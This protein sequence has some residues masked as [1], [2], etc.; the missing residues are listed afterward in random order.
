MKLIQ[1]F[2]LLPFV[3]TLS[4]WSASPVPYSGKID[5]RGVNYFGEAQFAFSLHDGNGTTHWENGNQPKE[6]I[7]VTIRNGRYSVLLGGQGMN[8]LAPQ[9]FLN[10]DKLYLKVEVDMGDG[11]GL[12][13][14]APDQLITATPR[15]LVA[16]WAKM[17]KL[18][19][20]VPA[21]SITRDMLSQQVLTQ[22]D[23]NGSS[24]TVGP[25]TRDMLPASVLN[26]LNKT[27]VITRD[28]LPQDVRDDLNQSIVI[29]RDMLPQDVRD[30]LNK[31]VM[32]TRS[33]LPADVLSDLNR[34]IS[35]SMLGSDLIADLN[36]TIGLSRLSSEVIAK[37]NQN[38]TVADGSVTASKIASK[39]I[40]KDQISDSI[41]KYLKPEITAQPQAS[42]IYAA[43]DGTVSFSAEGKYL[44]Y[45]WKKNSLDLTGE[46]NATLNITDAN[47]T[48]HGGNYSVVVSNDFGSVESGEVEMF[49]NNTGPINGLVGWWKFDETSGIV[50]YDSSGNGNDGNLT[51][52]PTWTTGKIGGA[53]SFD[54]FDDLVTMGNVTGGLLNFTLSTWVKTN[55]PRS[56][57][58]VWKNPAILGT[59]QLSGSGS[60][61][62]LLGL[63]GGRLIWFDEIQ[64]SM[65]FDTSQQ[66]ADNKWCFIVFTR[67]N[68][69]YKFFIGGVLK[70]E[71]VGTA[72]VLAERTIDVGC[73]LYSGVYHFNGLIDDVRIYD[74][75]LSVAEVQSLYNMG[76]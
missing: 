50:A 10:H 33:M 63:K 31:T 4:L 51:N 66:I 55:D 17:A 22:L 65:T 21:G 43:G 74:R 16:E 47:A 58:T 46:T 67:S 73:S 27:I 53:L 18:A 13:H 9:L 5:I 2:L 12:R 25:I 70:A 60:G 52:G 8:S 23:A 6:T 1:P 32:I 36:S 40:G 24:S 38:A 35:K 45:Q 37:L 57:A 56:E 64:S 26:D 39:A 54:G 34:T 59:R 49:I 76:Q 44:T 30:D 28:M 48:L 29:T 42:T 68:T 7:K 20:A 69:S 19:E 61:E 3:F 71:T 15:A 14:L 62:Y 72:N 11:E 75:A 41:L